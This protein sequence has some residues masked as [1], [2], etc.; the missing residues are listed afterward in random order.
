MISS[1]LIQS[2]SSILFLYYFLKD[3]LFSFPSFILFMDNIG[4]ILA[5]KGKNDYEI[6]AMLARSLENGEIQVIGTSDFA[7]YRKTFDKDPSLARRF[8]KIIVEAPSIEESLDILFGLKST[9]ENFHKVKYED[10]IPV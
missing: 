2:S 1:G 6:S 7:S 5:D 9:Y 10:A 4:A 8:Q 3:N